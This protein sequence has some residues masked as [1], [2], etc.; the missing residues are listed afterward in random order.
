M[1][2]DIMIIV[3]IVLIGLAAM[4]FIP[5]WRMKRTIPKVIRV[6]RECSAIDAKN[7]RTIDELGLRPRGMME[8]M[9][10]GRDY[11]QYALTALMRAGIIETTDD[12]RLYLVEEKLF[13]SGLE[14]TSPYHR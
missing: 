8:G 7:A 1:G 4:F 10:R 3:L 12:G 13:E 9:L 2:T 14:K 5:Q 6:F 11:R